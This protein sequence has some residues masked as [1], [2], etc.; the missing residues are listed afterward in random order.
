MRTALYDVHRE[1]GAKV[2]D[3]HGWDM[4]IQYTSIL[5]EHGATRGA[6][7][8]FDLSHM[9]RVWVSGRDR[10]AYLQKLL[11]IDVAKVRPGRCKYT[12]LL[13]ERGTVI[14][15]L[16]LYDDSTRDRSLLVVNASNREKDVEWMKTI[17]GGFDVR[18]DDQTVATTLLAV[19]GPR[20]LDVMRDAFGVDPSGLK[21]YAFDTF[22]VLGVKDCLVS[23]TGYTGEDGFE[24]CF[25]NSEAARAWKAAL[26]KGAPHGLRPVGLG[27]RDTL[28][29]EAGMPLYGQELDDQTTP[30]EAGLNFAVSLDKPDFVG[31]GALARQKAEG[32]TKV[33]VGFHMDGKRIPRHDMPVVAGGTACGKVTSGT[34]SPTLQKPI[35]MAYVPPAHAAIGSRIAVDL[36]GKQEPATIVK[37]PFYSRR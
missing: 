27:A 37:L 3:F 20:C 17:A 15:D 9:G 12:F 5:E 2:V 22:T 7:G 4:P 34:F 29:T 32:V 36:R 8:L 35:G 30:L 16:I 10:T 25:P 11:T 23:R 26:D 13:T 6:A 1:M 14:D 19:Q 31:K 28:R 21:Y 24:V 33:L 18:F